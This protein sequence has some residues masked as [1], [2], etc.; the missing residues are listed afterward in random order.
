MLICKS[1]KKEVC[2]TIN[3]K[4]EDCY[5]SWEGLYLSDKIGLTIMISLPIIVFIGIMLMA[6]IK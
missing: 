6:V 5:Y 1:C 4:C 2:S 3:D